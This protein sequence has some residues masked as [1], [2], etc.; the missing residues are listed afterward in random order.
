MLTTRTFKGK[1]CIA[2]YTHVQCSPDDAR[3]AGMADLATQLLPPRTLCTR[4]MWPS[5]TK[6]STRLASQPISKRHRPTAAG[7]QPARL[8]NETGVAVPS[9]SLSLL[10][11]SSRTVATIPGRGARRVVIV[12]IEKIVLFYFY[13]SR[14]DL[15]SRKSCALGCGRALLWN[16]LPV[17]RR[18]FYL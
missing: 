17:A 6:R 12:S 18:V 3:K 14:G 5:T 11:S 8:H 16:A 10:H 2:P 4:V 15:K 7:D 1:L 9:P 13:T